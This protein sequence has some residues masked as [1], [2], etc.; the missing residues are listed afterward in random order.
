MYF[1]FHYWILCRCHVSTY[2][3][4]FY[5]LIS[6]PALVDSKLLD[7][8]SGQYKTASTHAFK[9]RWQRLTYKVLAEA[10]DEPMSSWAP[11]AR[12]SL[13]LYLKLWEKRVSC[14]CSAKPHF[15]MSWTDD[16]AWR[17]FRRQTHNSHPG[18]WSLRPA[19]HQES[20]VVFR[21][22]KFSA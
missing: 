21:T 2:Q 17:T 11:A 7:N 20:T 19:W 22:N 18:D 10:M 15:Q 4:R 12:A 14:S 16:V 3:F 13:W 9:Q 1:T 8:I 5:S 6:L